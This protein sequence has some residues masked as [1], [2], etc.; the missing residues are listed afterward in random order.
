MAR[1][2]HMGNDLE[3]MSRPDGIVTADRSV[4][5][6]E[7]LLVFGLDKET[8]AYI[9]YITLQIAETVPHALAAILFGSVA[10]HSARPLTDPCPSDVDV[11]V[12]CSSEGDQEA[13]S[14]LQHAALSR[15]VVSGYEAHPNTPRDVEVLGA[16]TH[17]KGWD[18]TF[19]ANVAR[20]GIVLWARGPLSDVLSPLSE[21]ALEKAR[22]A[23]GG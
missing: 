3:N 1:N 14:S 13:I 23:K 17:F 10:R 6:A 8:A 15:A 16:L 22:E 12:V 11:L 18:D 5:T 7:L 20:E 21:R 2:T 9:R 19:V 4:S